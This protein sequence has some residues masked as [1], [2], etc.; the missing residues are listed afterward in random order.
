M[1]VKLHQVEM[2]QI[3][4]CFQEVITQLAYVKPNCMTTVFWQHYIYITCPTW[5]INV[6]T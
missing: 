1:A 6:K 3:T 4:T 5:Q 2:Q